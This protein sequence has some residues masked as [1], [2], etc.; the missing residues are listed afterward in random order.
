MID[1]RELV[2]GLL[3]DSNDRLDHNLKGDWYA[4]DDQL[5]RL[6]HTIW[7]ELHAVLEKCTPD[8]TGTEFY[9]RVRENIEVTVDEIIQRG[10]R[11]ESR[12]AE[13]EPQPK[14]IIRLALEQGIELFKDE[15]NQCYAAY[16]V[17]QHREIHP[18][19]SEDCKDWL[20]L[21]LWESEEIAVAKETVD[22]A[23][24]I[25]RARAKTEGT[26]HTLHNRAAFVDGVLWYDLSDDE[27]RAVRIT[28]TGWEIVNRPPILFRRYPHMQSQAT[29]E[30]GGSIEDFFSLQNLPRGKDEESGKDE[31]LLFKVNQLISFIPHIPR[32]VEVL[33][34]KPGSVKSG[35][36]KLTKALVDPS[37][38]GEMSL[39][40]DP[41]GLIQ[42]L[43]QHYL[44]VF[45]NVTKLDEEQSN[46]L[47]R[48]VTGEGHQTRQL[49]TD[50]GAFI[51]QFKRAIKINGIN[52]PPGLPDW[53]ERVVTHELAP[54]VDDE[55]K[56]EEQALKTFDQIRGKCLGAAFS[57]ISK[58]LAKKHDVNLR[59]KP[60]M[61]DYC[62]WGEAIARAMGYA[63]G[64]FTKAYAANRAVQN[65]QTIQDDPV[66]LALEKLLD[67]A[68]AFVGTA[69]NLLNELASRAETLGIDTKKLRRW[70]GA[71]NALSRHLN[72][73]RL[74]LE[75][76]GY[77]VD[78][79]SR[80]TLAKNLARNPKLAEFKTRVDQ[81]NC[82][83]KTMVYVI[84]PRTDEQPSPSIDEWSA[85][86]NNT[87]PNTAPIS[88]M[89]GNDEVGAMERY[90]SILERGVE[91]G[92]GAPEV[93][94]TA[95]SLQGHQDSLSGILERYSTDNT[96]PKRLKAIA[97]DY[98][99]GMRSPQLEEKHG[100]TWVRHARDKGVIPLL[101][102]GP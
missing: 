73:L 77:V 81:L 91:R 89:S 44:P 74:N 86:D 68:P 93:E 53:K 37:S 56:T 85:P 99:R 23:V 42:A 61:A 30:V 92:V 94:K 12:K 83:R 38:I 25:L 8:E 29:P 88:Q 24:R 98:A 49:Y 34:G 60:R 72:M 13:A 48:A 57:I 17:G 21:L 40:D 11:K 14:R 62:E 22:T 96:A 46:I 9:Q 80:E 47:S 102:G 90:S 69:T 78:H 15:R 59:K 52:I 101:G 39:A 1:L 97:E 55:R 79:D 65:I 95:I 32:C 51:R 84:R 63:D 16:N 4:R 2:R 18:L 35:N 76:L 6:N 75:N 50:D 41:N 27:W 87:A 28:E 19:D 36:Q 82:S 26:R 7:R 20:G 45:G 43:E 58:A 33:Y 66:G 3:L 10:E 70:P 31:E 71:P 100:A 54:V 5:D 67:E 64:A